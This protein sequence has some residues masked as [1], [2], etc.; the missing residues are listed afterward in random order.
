MIPVLFPLALFVVFVVFVVAI[1]M[2]VDC[3]FVFSDLDTNIH[4]FH[5]SSCP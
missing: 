5:E 2:V 4:Q 1:V 3:S